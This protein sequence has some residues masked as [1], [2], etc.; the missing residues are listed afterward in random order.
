MKKLALVLSVL[1]HPV[2]M[3]TFATLA[4]F[5][6]GG[7]YPSLTESQK[8][9]VI[10]FVALTT[11]LIPLSLTPLYIGL[12]IVRNVYMSTKRERVLPLLISSIAY[13]VAYYM[14]RRIFPDR[15]L[16]AL[17]AVS[18]V[19]IATVAIVS[20]FWKLSA[21]MSAVGGVFATLLYTGVLW[22]INTSAWIVVIAL[23]AG[24]VAW[25]RMYVGSHSVAQLIAGLFLGIAMGL[26]GLPLA[27]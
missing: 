13:V 5:H 24:I 22:Q 10:G 20:Y 14:V 17:L 3:T 27:L 6:T 18:A 15:L 23:I 8:W 11:M 1:F 19:L 2:F 16:L 9:L 7:E 25:A 21:H 26:I 4:M 12:G